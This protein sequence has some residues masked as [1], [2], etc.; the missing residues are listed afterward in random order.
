MIFSTISRHDIDLIKRLSERHYPSYSMEQEVDSYDKKAYDQ[1]RSKFKSIANVIEETFGE[2]YGP[3][4]VEN[5][6]S[7]PVG[8]NH[9][10]RR[11]WS[12]VFK[13]SRK[14]QYS[15]QIIAGIDPL[16]EAVDIGFSFGLA[17]SRIDEDEK[18]KLED[19]L[20]RL[21]LILHDAITTNP[22]VH[23]HLNDLLEMGF[24]C[25]VMGNLVS[26]GDWIA[27]LLV[28]PKFS[29][30]T[31]KL[32]AEEEG[33][34]NTGLMEYYVAACV[35]LMSIF[36]FEIKPGRKGNGFLPRPRTPEERS[37]E[38]ELRTKIGIEG[39]KFALDYERKKLAKLK[40]VNKGYPKHIAAISDAYHY[41]ILSLDQNGK[42]HIEVKTTARRLGDTYAE[43]CYMS[44]AEYCFFKDH[45]HTYR[46]YR[47]YDIFGQPQLLEINLDDVLFE[48]DAYRMKIQS[49]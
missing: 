37:R 46:M 36:P 6:T 17:S 1:V 18:R 26:L 16:A 40:L 12:C 35:P 22:D 42:I 7:N 27:N 13:G 24:K 11:I 5:N 48:T 25:Y 33:E 29:S 31:I 30:I 41:D 45:P 9:K 14:K 2:K 20:R 8:Q 28:E 19:G 23:L 3:F 4:Q 15:A 44:A 34:V 39:E 38:A 47:V 32:P 10:L 49:G 43:I 21:G